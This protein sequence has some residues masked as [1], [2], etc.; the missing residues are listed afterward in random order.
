[1]QFKI[2]TQKLEIMGTYVAM[3]VY[4]VGPLEN[5]QKCSQIQSQR[6]QFF[7]ISG[8]HP[9][10]P[11]CFARN[12][13]TFFNTLEHINCL[14]PGIRSSLVTPLRISS[15]REEPILCKCTLRLLILCMSL[16]FVG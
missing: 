16:M 9:P 1:M 13:Y 2:K 8:G 4:Y 6:V 11:S 12:E 15:S 5:S 3:Y 14:G 7:K 10:K